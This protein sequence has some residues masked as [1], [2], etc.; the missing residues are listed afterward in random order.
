MMRRGAVFLRRLVLIV[1]A[2][3]VACSSTRAATGHPVASALEPIIQ[4]GPERRARAGMLHSKP[5]TAYLPT[6]GT[7][8]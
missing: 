2:A 1:L 7:S 8:T 6:M 4:L 3:T 5:A